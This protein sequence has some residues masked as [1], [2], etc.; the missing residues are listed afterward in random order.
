MENP[1]GN[2]GKKLDTAGKYDNGRKQN[3]DVG[4]GAM[5]RFGLYCVCAFLLAIQAKADPLNPVPNGT[6]GNTLVSLGP[7]QV[8]VAETIIP[9]GGGTWQYSFQVTSNDPF[10]IWHFL[11]YTPFSTFSGTATVFP[12]VAPTGLSLNAVISG[13][14]ARNIDASLTTTTNMWYTPFGGPNGLPTGG[15]ATEAFDANTLFNGPI[16]YAYEDVNSGYL[17]SGSPA[18]AAY[19]YASTAV[20]E[21]GTLLLLGSGLLGMAGYGRKKL[22]R[23]PAA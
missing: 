2:E 15:T 18:V 12:N 6:G 13:Y 5:K 8:S 9:L 3:C 16:L 10:N 1:A 23:S 21:P 17:G 19:G 7:S 20:P 4:R 11:V 14:D 22:R